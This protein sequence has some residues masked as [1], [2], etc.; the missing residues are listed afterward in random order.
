MGRAP[1]LESFVCWRE[2]EKTKIFCRYWCQQQVVALEAGSTRFVPIRRE[3]AEK[4]GFVQLRPSRA[5]SKAVLRVAHDPPDG[6]AVDAR[7]GTGEDT[8]AEDVS[9]PGSSSRHKEEVGGRR[10]ASVGSGRLGDAVLAACAWEKEC[11]KKD[12]DWPTGEGEAGAEAGGRTSGGR[13][14]PAPNQGLLL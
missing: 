6:G 12:A 5:A 9:E 11:L 4:C 3:W 1:A 14:A 2:T 13:G 10:R 8:S 7:T